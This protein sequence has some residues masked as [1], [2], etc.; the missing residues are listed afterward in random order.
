MLL[1]SN[2]QALLAVKGHRHGPG[3]LP[4]TSAKALAEL[5]QVLLIQSADAHTDGCS[6]CRVAP[7]QHENAPVPAHGYI[8]GI[9]KAASVVPIV[10]NADGFDV[11]ESYG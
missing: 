3:E 1:V 7:I 8:I 11:F 5:S 4:V 2:V 10:H 9:G 6:T